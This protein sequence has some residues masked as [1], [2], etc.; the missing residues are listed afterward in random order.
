MSSKVCST[1]CSNDDY[2]NVLCELS[3]LTSFL[4]IVTSTHYNCSFCLIRNCFFN[5]RVW[6]ERHFWNCFL[7]SF[8]DNSFYSA[9]CIF[10]IQFCSYYLNISRICLLMISPSALSLY[11]CP[12]TK[13]EGLFIGY[14][15]ALNSCHRLYCIRV[16]TFCTDEHLLLAQIVFRLSTSTFIVV[17]LAALVLVVVRS[18]GKYC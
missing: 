1:I 7:I 3:D 12:D 13:R 16:M 8:F 14:S 15:Y 9:L 10:S 17:L 4:I 11:C 18:P 2:F 6:F 5:Y